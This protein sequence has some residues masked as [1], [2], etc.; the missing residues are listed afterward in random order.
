MDYMAKCP[1]CEVELH[2]QDFFEVF[3]KE[4]K[5][6]KVK[7]KIGKFSGESISV[8][9]KN[10]VKMWVCPSCDKIIGFSEYKWD[11]KM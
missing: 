5:K 3:Q 4:S 11:A 7:T 1:Y 10:H 2:L 9:F 6:G 8:G